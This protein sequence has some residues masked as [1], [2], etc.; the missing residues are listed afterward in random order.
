MGPMTHV[1]QAVPA[2]V[3]TVMRMKRALMDLDGLASLPTVDMRQW[4]IDLFGSEPR[5][6]VVVAE[7]GNAV[8]GMAIYSGKCVAG[9]AEPIAHLQDLFVDEA[10]RR[11]GIGS[12]ILQLV[13]ADAR[14][15]GMSMIELN[16]RAN[17]PAREFYRR[18]GFEHLSQCLT[19]VVSGSTLIE[20]ADFASKLAVAG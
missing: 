7:K 3:P 12:R 16:V 5:Y 13:A 2:D 6:S 15:R 8:V 4:L 18:I 17:N 20:L 14:E 11:Q 9:Y 19:Y 10:H 1:R